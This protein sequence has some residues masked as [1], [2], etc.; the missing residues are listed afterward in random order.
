MKAKLLTRAGKDCR[1]IVPLTDAT[2]ASW[3]ARLQA[4]GGTGLLDPV[5]TGEEGAER[6]A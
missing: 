3:R 4:G 2:F 5:E 6:R 1:T